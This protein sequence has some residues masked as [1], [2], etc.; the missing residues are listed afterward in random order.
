MAA[1]T[2]SLDVAQHI[3]YWQRCFNSHLPSL[4]TPNDS[5]RLT[6]ASFIV[7]ALELLS[8]PLSAEDRTSIQSWVLSLQHPDGGFCGSPTHMLPGQDAFKGS[9][10]LAATFFALLL[11]AIAADSDAEARAAFARVRRRKLLRWLRRLQR[12]D[13]SFGQVLWEGEAVGGRDMRHS[14]LASC[15]RWMLRGG[16]DKDQ[17]PAG[18]EDDIDVGRMMVD[19]CHAVNIPAS[20]RYLLEMTQ[21][22][23]GGFS[24]CAGGHPDLYHSYLGLAALAVM[25]DDDLKQLDVAL[26]C[27]KETVRKVQL[28]RDGLLDACRE[29]EDFGSDGFW[30]SQNLVR[31]LTDLGSKSKSEF[32]DPCQEAAQR[33]Y[34]CLYRNGGDKAMCGEYFQYVRL[35]REIYPAGVVLTA[36]RAYRE[37]KAA[38]IVRVCAESQLDD[39]NAKFSAVAAVNKFVEDGTVVKGVDAIDLLEWASV[40][41][42]PED[43]FSRTLGPLRVRAVKASPKDKIAATRCLQSCLLHWDL[44]S[45]QQESSQCPP[46]K[47]KLYGM[48]ALKQVERAAQLTEQAHVSNP[49]GGAPARGV[50]TEEEILLL[51]KVVETH[52][53]PEDLEKLVASPVF[54]PAVQLRLGRRELFLRVSQR[55]RKQH[56]W[57]QLCNLC[58]DCL[59]DN[60]DADE[61]SLRACD[62]SVW[63]Q[64]IEAAAQLKSCNPDIVSKLQRLLLKL[65]A[66]KSLKPIYKRNIHLARVAAAFLLV[67][68]DEDDVIDGRPASLRLQELLH[69]VDYHKLSAAC[70][71][72]VKEFLELLDAEGLKH[73]AY[74]YTANLAEEAESPLGSARIKVLSLKL[75]L[76]LTT[77]STA[78]TPVAGK[79]AASRCLTCGAKFEAESCIACLATTSS[80]ALKTYVSA[81]KEFADNGAIQNEILP[82]LA[83]IVALCSAKSAFPGRPGYAA[84]TPAKSQH[85][86]RALLMLEHQVF[87]TPKHG[88]TC[89][90]L[91]QLHL[92]VG[93]AHRCREIW[94]E[95]SVKR[96]IVDSLAP[97]FYDRLSTISPVILDSSDNWGWELVETL[98]S[99]YASNLRLKMP[100]RLIDA[101]EA[102]SYAS[103]IDM[104]EFIQNLRSGCTRVMSLVEEARADRLLGEPSGEFLNDARY[105]TAAVMGIDYTFVTEMMGRISNSMAK[106]LRDAPRQCT[107]SEILY[108][109]AVHLL[110][111]L[112]PLSLG[113]NRSSPTPSVLGQVVEAVKASMTSQLGD[114]PVLDGTIQQSVSG[115]RSFHNVTMLRDTAM[116]SSLAATWILSFNERERERDRS[117]SSNLP[118]EVI[119]QIKSLQGAAEAALQQGKAFIARLKSVVD[120]GSQF[121]LDLRAWVFEGDGQ[122]LSGLIEDGTVK[123][124]VESWRQNIAGWGQVKWER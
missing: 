15:I 41:L 56:S 61:P 28:A 29:R 74:V 105:S 40:D 18:H 5:T 2:K 70:F 27:S 115:L 93:S 57:E 67:T 33:S 52:G 9:A 31:V 79:D 92:L 43:A 124:L 78:R 22:K 108:Y 72:D 64:Y 39:P 25:V 96:A 66:A 88:Q 94:H 114:L 90:L 120:A 4:Y 34:K 97:I 76:F 59:S 55:Y 26:C 86:L 80:A 100:R 109:E 16:L 98:R 50:K 53:S 35:G 119:T 91:V 107:A 38:W 19:S 122:E 118:K 36:S 77:C 102:G 65:A 101:F 116:A 87:L 20:R 42:M 113:I 3:R 106:F 45:A 46:E 10:N 89:L 54:S 14:Y 123:E 1:S 75:Q 68:N 8:S 12:Q 7:S 49:E 103:I 62:W 24:K 37:C 84:A 30:E 51:Y 81:G 63:K 110:A 48:L 32:Y 6:F 21:Q 60:N 117:G 112:I 82:E 83:M 23:F 95:L 58:H 121:G 13:G 111:T 69:Y 104:S 47:K 99:H 85:L 17:D 11:L 44:V 73:V 71:E